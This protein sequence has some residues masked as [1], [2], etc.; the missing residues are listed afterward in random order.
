[1]NWVDIVILSVIG[2]SVFISVCR[3]FVREVLSIVT[4][5]V[6]FWVAF[7]FTPALAGHLVNV[8][9]VP[10]LR[11]ATAFLLLLIGTLILG[12]IVNYV[13]GRLIVRTGLSGT[14]R[15]LGIV[16][17]VARGIIIVGI[18]VLLAHATPLTQDPWWQESVLLPR[19][20]RLTS[21]ALA[22]LPDS[23]AAHFR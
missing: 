11:S 23:I 10:S 19:F 14:D 20:D 3:G 8:I 18:L 22:W 6:A 7:L 2:V 13:V 17:G 21:F 1:M 4:W 15:L 9:E 16:F 5:V 12:A